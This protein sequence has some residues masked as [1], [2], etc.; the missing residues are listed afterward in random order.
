[1]GNVCTQV[2]EATTTVLSTLDTDGWMMMRLVYL[3]N[4]RNS[5]ME[6]NAHDYSQK[7]VISQ[8]EYGWGMRKEHKKSCLF[9]WTSLNPS[10]RKQTVIHNAVFQEEVD[11]CWFSNLSSNMSL[12]TTRHWAFQKPY[13]KSEKPRRLLLTHQTFHVKQKLG[14]GTNSSAKGNEWQSSWNGTYDFLIF[15]MV[16]FFWSKYSKG[17]PFLQDCVSESSNAKWRVHIT[18]N[19]GLGLLQLVV[20]GSW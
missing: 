12:H 19:T 14:V 9:Q 15:Y 16:D 18:F 7:S 3:F 1:M 4:K 5:L 11:S 20:F 13:A 17:L 6:L 2:L 10:W 8:V